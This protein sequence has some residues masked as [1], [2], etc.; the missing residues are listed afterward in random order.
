MTKLHLKMSSAKVAAILSRPQCSNNK[1]IYVYVQLCQ[2]FE[3]VKKKNSCKI[4]IQRSRYLYR[5]RVSSKNICN[6]MKRANDGL[7]M[8]T[9]HVIIFCAFLCIV[10]FY[11]SLILARVTSLIDFLGNNIIYTGSFI[12]LW[13]TLSRGSSRT[14]RLLAK[15]GA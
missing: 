2:K 11:A 14:R 6:K 10:D 12:I 5:L 15:P 8:W 9:E 1:I 4:R 3:A 7:E 13:C